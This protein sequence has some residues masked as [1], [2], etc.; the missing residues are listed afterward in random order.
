MGDVW[1]Q[2]GGKDA[3]VSRRTIGDLPRAGLS[4]VIGFGSVI[5]GWCLASLGDP[6]GIPL[7]V[8]GLAIYR[9]TGARLLMPFLLLT[10]A[11]VYGAT[12]QA[13]KG[14]KRLAEANKF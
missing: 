8:Q 11:E 12:V 13:D 2:I 1:H 9:G 5:R 3:S 10:L 4:P 6:E 14:L 7:I